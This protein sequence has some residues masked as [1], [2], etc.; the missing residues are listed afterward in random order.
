MSISAGGYQEK[1]KRD[2]HVR[3]TKREINP[4]TK[5]N[6]LEDTSSK[7]RAKWADRWGG[8]PWPWAPALP[9]WPIMCNLV[10]PTSTVFEDE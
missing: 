9:R 5:K 1:T 7:G 8:R 6:N 4:T 3:F 10:D 2:P